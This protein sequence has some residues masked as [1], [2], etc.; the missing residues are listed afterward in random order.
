MKF[1]PVI[2]FR[3]KWWPTC[4][5][6]LMMAILFLLCA[7]QVQRADWKTEIIKERTAKLSM[8]PLI[9]EGLPEGPIENLYY[10]GAYVTSNVKIARPYYSFT[11]NSEHGIGFQL[12]FPEMWNGNRW[13][14]RQSDFLTMEEWRA[15]DFHWPSNDELE[16]QGKHEQLGV[17]VPL[18]DPDILFPLKEKGGEP[19]RPLAQIE[20]L[21][22]IPIHEWGDTEHELL[23]AR[24]LNIPNNH[25]AYALTWFS[26]AIALGVIYLAQ[27]VTLRFKS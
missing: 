8:K 21:M 4:L 16:K 11:H 19:I 27:H 22:F 24:L 17:F 10:R 20:P 25:I 9:L 14:L 3:P 18:D 12:F 13:L 26:L 5:T 1:V 7:W 2:E 15:G 6:I 23:K